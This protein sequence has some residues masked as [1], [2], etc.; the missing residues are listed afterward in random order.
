[1]SPPPSS[2]SSDP[3]ASVVIYTPN[4]GCGVGIDPFDISLTVGFNIPGC[5]HIVAYL[6]SRLSVLNMER[7][8]PMPDGNP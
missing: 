6:V 2:V 7:L 3:R 5:L 1:M 4:L 8:I